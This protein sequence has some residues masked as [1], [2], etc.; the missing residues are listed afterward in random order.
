VY[1]ILEKYIAERTSTIAG[2]ERRE[3]I[4]KRQK[5]IWE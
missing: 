2:D 3:F 1:I 5:K 4:A